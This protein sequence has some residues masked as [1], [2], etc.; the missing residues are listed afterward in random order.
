MASIRSLHL[1]LTRR[2][3]AVRG[4]INLL[5]PPAKMIRW[6]LVFPVNRRLCYHA[7]NLVIGGGALADSDEPIPI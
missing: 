2:T 1:A 5:K 6:Q 3:F 7:S 4:L